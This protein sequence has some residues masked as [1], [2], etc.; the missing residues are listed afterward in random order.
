M[1]NQNVNAYF[2]GTKLEHLANV[3]PPEEQ[4][5]ASSLNGKLELGLVVCGEVE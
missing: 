1:V 4:P 3:A 2:V 5:A